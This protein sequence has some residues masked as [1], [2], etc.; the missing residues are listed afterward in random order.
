MK[1]ILFIGTHKNYSGLRLA[2]ALGT[3]LVWKG[4]E[5]LLAGNGEELPT[6]LQLPMT[7]IPSKATAK[8]LA[9]LLQKNHIEKVIS[10]AYLPGC[11][12]ALS[13]NIPFVYIEPENLKEA[14][15]VKNFSTQTLIL[16][17]IKKTTAAPAAVPIKGIIS[18]HKIHHRS[19]L[20]PHNIYS[21]NI[22]AIP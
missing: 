5:V 19:I 22:K 3:A 1:T 14:K 7:A 9:T 20:S 4:E 8:T 12:A 11:E 13:L 17:F 16:L 21:Y 2:A 15:P 18:P 6:Y 10:L